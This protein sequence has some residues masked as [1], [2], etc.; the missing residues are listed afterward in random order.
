MHET[1]RKETLAD[2]RSPA[3][4]GTDTL[5]RRSVGSSV[6]VFI[7][8]R[9]NWSSIS[10]ETSGGSSSFSLRLLIGLPI[11]FT[12]SIQ[13]PS[14]VIAG[15]AGRCFSSFSVPLQLPSTMGNILLQVE[16][17]RCLTPRSSGP[18]P[19]V[20][21]WRPLGAVTHHHQRAANRLASNRP[22]IPA[23]IRKSLLAASSVR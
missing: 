20:G 4:P 22:T 11:S 18:S 23:L 6:T 8:G 9:G 7:A 15:R 13:R 19:A 1:V 2:P 14:Q 16:T 17:E 21:Y 5:A 12:R 3:I 10:L